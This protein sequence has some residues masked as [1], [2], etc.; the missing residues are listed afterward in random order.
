MNSLPLKIC[1]KLIWSKPLEELHG[2]MNFTCL[3]GLGLVSDVAKVFPISYLLLAR[4]LTRKRRP[5]HARMTKSDPKSRDRL[6]VGLDVGD[7]S[8][9][10]RCMRSIERSGSRTSRVADQFATG[11]ASRCFG[12]LLCVHPHQVRPNDM[13]GHATWDPISWSTCVVLVS[14]WSI[15]KENWQER[16]S[17]RHSPAQILTIM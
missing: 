1:P 2:K 15:S 12:Q 16:L 17:Q 14:S 8:G 3:L 13:D 10:G 7:R 5:R 11:L 9:A 4:K 6:V